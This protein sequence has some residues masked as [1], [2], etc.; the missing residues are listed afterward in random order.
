MINKNKNA[1][2]Q[3]TRFLHRVL[4][5]NV[6]YVAQVWLQFTE[7]VTERIFVLSY[8]FV[9]ISMITDYVTIRYIPV[10]Q[11]MFKHIISYCKFKQLLIFEF[12]FVYLLHVIRLDYVFFFFILLD[13][14]IMLLFFS[15]PQINDFSNGFQCIF[16]FF[17]RVLKNIAILKPF[18]LTLWMAAP[19]VLQYFLLYTFHHISHI[20]S[21]YFTPIEN[22]QRFFN[23]CRFCINKLTG[24]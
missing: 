3:I 9:L 13:R 2:S 1:A 7:N 17:K 20:S 10:I 4:P 5:V 22:V 12:P 8:I 19:D 11:I 14:L 18:L 15:F 23:T 6:I 24:R 21:Q 16:L